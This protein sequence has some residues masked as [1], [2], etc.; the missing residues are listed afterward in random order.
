[1]KHAVLVCVLAAGLC[2]VAQE[3]S[4]EEAVAELR[5]REASY[6]DWRAILDHGQDSVPH[7]TRLLKD[8]DDFL[9]A[10]AAVLLYRLGQTRMLDSLAALLESPNA[11]ARKEAAAAL[12]AFVGQPMGFEPSAP[13]PQREAA[14]ERWQTWWKANREKALGLK[15]GKQLFGKVTAVDEQTGLVAVSV[16]GRHGLRRGMTLQVRRGDSFVC[17]LKVV[18]APPDGGAGRIVKL[19]DRLAPKPGDRVV[20]IE[21]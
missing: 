13:A 14:L 11:A 12:Q 3:L 18:A 6:G 8:R 10:Q 16:T 1:M 15:P 17:Q 4:P 2:V 19:S 21:R 9:R 20:Y 5:D 7:L